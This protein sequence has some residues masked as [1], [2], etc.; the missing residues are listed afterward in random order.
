MTASVEQLEDLVRGGA[1]I[2][3]DFDGPICSVFAGYAAPAIASE[4]RDMLGA[5]A[6]EFETED[7]PLQLLVRLDATA[8]AATVRRIADALRDKELLAV[9]SA[10]ETIG[11]LDT[12]RAA[13]MAGRPTAVVSNNSVSAVRSYLERHEVLDHVDIISARN[14]GMRPSLLKPHPHL[15]RH[16]LER[17]DLSPNRVIFV[18][19]SSSDVIA[20]HAAGVSTIGYGKSAEKRKRLVDAGADYITD[21]MAEI[22]SA[23]LK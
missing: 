14:D 17:L 15:V 16:A 3:L 11:A 18:G 8:P 23:L 22:A 6:A 7:D 21:S 4:L 12:L 10:T 2:L 13:R 19:D 5:N 9:K 1:A 20:G